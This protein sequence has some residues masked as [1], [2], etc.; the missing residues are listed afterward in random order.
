MAYGQ[1]EMSRGRQAGYPTRIK[2]GEGED[3]KSPPELKGGAAVHR[4]MC[5]AVQCNNEC[6]RRKRELQ[7]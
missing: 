2:A 1:Q 7:S 3:R 5:S 4:R 6:K